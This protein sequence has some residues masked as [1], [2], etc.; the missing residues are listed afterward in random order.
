MDRMGLWLE[1]A[2]GM[3]IVVAFTE[4]CRIANLLN[5]VVGFEHND[6]TF[7][8]TAKDDPHELYLLWLSEHTGVVN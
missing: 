4:C 7:N 3:S 6:E 5:V 1:C 2:D 8:I